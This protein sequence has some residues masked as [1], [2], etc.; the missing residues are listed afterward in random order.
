MSTLMQLLN[1][2]ETNRFVETYNYFPDV[3]ISGGQFL[4]K[5]EIDQLLQQGYLEPATQD[6]FGAS[7]EL[8][9]WAKDILH[10]RSFELAA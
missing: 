8:S 5:E 1:L 9:S 4:D 2:I 3:A 10:N 6:R 7:L